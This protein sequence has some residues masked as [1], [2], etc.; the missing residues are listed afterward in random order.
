MAYIDKHF[1]AI[2]GE[3][4]SGVNGTLFYYRTED[5]EATLVAADYFNSLKSI[6]KKGDII[7]V[8][9]GVDDVN[10]PSSSIGIL[11]LMV[12]DI[13]DGVVTVTKQSIL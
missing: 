12:T 9:A 13:T 3:T 11:I 6:L 2:G 5:D 1:N 7:E 4:R 8:L 10:S